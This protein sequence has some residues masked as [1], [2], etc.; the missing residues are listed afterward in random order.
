[1]SYR[2][3]VDGLHAVKGRWS[4]FFRFEPEYKT[5]HPCFFTF[6]LDGNPG[7]GILDPPG[8]VEFLG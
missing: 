6:Y 7:S 2:V 8:Q 5:F 1:V 3:K 4:R